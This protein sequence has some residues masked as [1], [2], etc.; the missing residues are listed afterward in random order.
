MGA[1][2]LDGILRVRSRNRPAT[3]FATPKLNETLQRARDKLMPKGR[4]QFPKLFYGTQ[5]STNPVTILVFVNEPRLFRGQ[6]A[7]YLEGVLRTEFDCAE[8]PIRIVFRKRD[9]V[10]LAE[11]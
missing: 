8:V 9:K 3:R 5:L 4:G 7:R 6:Y 2:D 10:V 11:L 1:G